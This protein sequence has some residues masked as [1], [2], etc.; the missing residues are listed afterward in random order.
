V[1]VLWNVVCSKTLGP[2]DLQGGWEANLLHARLHARATP[3]QNDGGARW[4]DHAERPSSA[5]KPV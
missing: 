1:S 3:S 4:V 5:Q 2:V